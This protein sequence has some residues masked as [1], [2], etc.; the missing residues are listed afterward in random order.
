MTGKH[1]KRTLELEDLEKVDLAYKE[2]DRR[3]SEIGQEKHMAGGSITDKARR[4]RN[5]V[6]RKN[7]SKRD[8]MD[9]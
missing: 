6:I 3:T 7:R 4:N 5:F 2:M 1:P 9:L 8:Q